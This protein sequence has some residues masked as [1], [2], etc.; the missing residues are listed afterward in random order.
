MWV[1]ITLAIRCLYC[2]FVEPRLP[3]DAHL[4]RILVINEERTIADSIA[5][6]LRRNGH[7]VL[8]LNAIDA[9]EHAE[10]LAF[11]VAIFGLTLGPTWDALARALREAMPNCKVVRCVERRWAGLL[12]AL[13]AESGYLA[14]DL[15][16]GRPA[17]KRTSPPTNPGRLQPTYTFKVEE[18][19]EQLDE[20][21]VQ[22]ALD[23]QFGSQWNV[24][25]LFIRRRKAV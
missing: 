17:V 19:L 25:P 24:S 9:V 5:E 4:M 15:K 7:N 21:R 8:P 10:H 6:A 23:A 20:I 1:S 3:Y 18:L 16:R 11:D 14:M 2:R 22:K 13:D 12:A